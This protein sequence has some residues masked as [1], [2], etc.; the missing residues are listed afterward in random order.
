MASRFPLSH[1]PQVIYKLGC[2]CAEKKMLVALTDLQVI[3]ILKA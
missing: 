2:Y 1:S 3:R